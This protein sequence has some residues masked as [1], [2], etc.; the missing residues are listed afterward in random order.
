MPL[1]IREFERAEVQV[2][3]IVADSVQYLG[4]NG[5]GKRGAWTPVAEERNGTRRL[6]KASSPGLKPATMTK[7]A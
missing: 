6:A 2:H 3:R 7:S 5:G 4:P 1:R